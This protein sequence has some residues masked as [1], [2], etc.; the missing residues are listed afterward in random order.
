ML[1][2]NL[3]I[4]GLMKSF[5]SSVDFQDPTPFSFSANLEI[6]NHNESWIFAISATFFRMYDQK[7]IC[8]AIVGYVTFVGDAPRGILFPALWPLCSQLG[9]P[10]RFLRCSSFLYGYFD[11]R[12]FNC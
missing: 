10:I 11:F 4:A 3:L 8:L 9:T 5:K 7:H 12:R 6:P 1:S 2:E